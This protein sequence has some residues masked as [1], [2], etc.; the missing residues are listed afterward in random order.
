[1]S[2]YI[3]VTNIFEYSNIRI[4]S[5]HSDV[6]RGVAHIVIIIIVGHVLSPTDLFSFPRGVWVGIRYFSSW[7]RSQNGRKTEKISTDRR[8]LQTDCRAFDCAVGEYIR[9]CGKCRFQ[10]LS[11]KFARFTL[12]DLP[13]YLTC[14][15]ILKQTILSNRPTPLEDKIWGVFII[16]QKSSCLGPINSSPTKS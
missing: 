13:N 14:S 5:S 7:M 16:F 8:V 12:R 1:M 9:N 6:Y 2:E 15:Y 3:F 11:E 4:Y 10:V